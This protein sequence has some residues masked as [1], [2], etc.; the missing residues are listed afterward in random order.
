MKT[1]MKAVPAF[2][3]A[4][5]LLA[6]LASGA[7]QTEKSTADAATLNQDLSLSGEDPSPWIAPQ[8][9]P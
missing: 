8:K 7:G 3:A 1:F 6:L 2:L 5:M 9:Q 4:A